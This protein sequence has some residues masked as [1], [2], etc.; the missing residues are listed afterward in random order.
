VQIVPP[1]ATPSGQA[2]IIRWGC[3]LEI[4]LGSD[5]AIVQAVIRQL[6]DSAGMAH[7]DGSQ[8]C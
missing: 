6:M 1:V 3:K 5:L 4:Q 7:S 8:S 2:T